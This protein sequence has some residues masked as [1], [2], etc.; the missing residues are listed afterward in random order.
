MFIPKKHTSKKNI[1]KLEPVNDFKGRVLVFLSQQPTNNHPFPGS[2]GATS[3]PCG[4]ATN[5]KIHFA[6]SLKN[7]STNGIFSVPKKQKI[8]QKMGNWSLNLFLLISLICWWI[9]F[10]NLQKKHQ[11]FWQVGPTLSFKK[12]SQK[13]HLVDLT[14][15]FLNHPIF[16]VNLRGPLFF[17]CRD[18]FKKKHSRFFSDLSPS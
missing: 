15:T 16:Y 11:I 1:E 8:Q 2:M 7:R 9:R 14:E 10:E 17:F 13:L 6:A 18:I 3:Q 12:F 5:P 4:S